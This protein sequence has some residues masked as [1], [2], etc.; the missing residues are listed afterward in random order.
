VQQSSRLCTEQPRTY[1]VGIMLKGFILPNIAMHCTSN[2][3]DSQ[4]N[5]LSTGIYN[6]IQFMPLN[7]ILG[8]PLGIANSEALVWRYTWQAH[9]IF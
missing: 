1:P 2:G 8:T 4:Y 6:L 9:V 7:E 5:K 3:Q